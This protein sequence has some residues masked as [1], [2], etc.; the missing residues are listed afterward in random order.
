MNPKTKAALALVSL[1]IGMFLL[2]EG[3]KMD[4]TVFDLAYVAV[5]AVLVIAYLPL[6]GNYLEDKLKAPRMVTLMPM[7]LM[8][9][10]ALISQGI[11][12]HGTK[13]PPIIEQVLFIAL[14]IALVVGS[15]IVIIKAKKSKPA[16]VATKP[17]KSQR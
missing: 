2:L 17:K 14:G 5:G 9:G 10:A 16:I 6:I 12:P 8:L 11:Y 4:N 7:L 15:A 13:V 3:S 1:A